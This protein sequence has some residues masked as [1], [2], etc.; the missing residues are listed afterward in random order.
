[1]S[2]FYDKIQQ[3]NK[4]YYKKQALNKISVDCEV[5]FTHLSTNAQRVCVLVL[6]MVLPLLQVPL[7]AIKF[8]NFNFFLMFKIAEIF[9][10]NSQHLCIKCWYSGNAQATIDRFFNKVILLPFPF[11][12]EQ[13]FQQHI[14]SYLLCNY[15]KQGI[16]HICI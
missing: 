7:E 10:V 11:P 5:S 9:Q 12:R 14:L 6:Y 2:I 16:L 15:I 13:F 4:F 1:M 3:N 8:S